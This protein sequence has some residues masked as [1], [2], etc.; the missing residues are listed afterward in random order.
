MK[1]S[2]LSPK[3]NLNRKAAFGFAKN[4][5]KIESIIYTVTVNLV[6]GLHIGAG[7]SAIEIGG[8]DN[9]I[10]KDKDGYPYIPGSSLKGKLRSLIELYAE[11]KEFESVNIGTDGGPHEFCDNTKCL[12]CRAFGIAKIKDKEKFQ[13]VAEKIGP[14]RLIF[15]DLMLSD[16]AVFS[17]VKEKGG[18]PIE[19]KTE[20]SID[21]NTGTGFNPRPLER[22]PAG[23]IFTGE[24]VF[25]VFDT[26]DDG[27]NRDY[28][29]I[30]TLFEGGLFK[31]LLEADYLGGQGSRGSGQ[32]IID[33]QR[34]LKISAI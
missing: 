17:A 31:K 1:R 4:M 6:T 25:R 32:V 26:G 7:D 18:N 34:K 2:S 8:I 11:G 9:Q 19:E 28:E 24:V 33:F 10:I 3:E 13:T 30:K 22:M 27:G 5:K 29:I 23:S 15:R 14:T 20:V 16:K 21:R 12:I